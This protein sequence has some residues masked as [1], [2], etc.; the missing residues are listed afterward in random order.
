L[1]VNQQRV[2]RLIHL[3]RRRHG[4]ARIAALDRLSA[5]RAPAP[6]FVATPAPGRLSI[7]TMTPTTPPPSNAVAAAAAEV[8]ASVPHSTHMPT[9]VVAPAATPCAAAAQPASHA[10]ASATTA[11]AG[12]AHPCLP[13]SATS[14]SF[15]SCSPASAIAEPAPTGA[16]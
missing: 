6:A 14:P 12:P 4:P 15:S 11:P 13:A 1:K 10:A 9:T 5:P 3:T 16:K 7:V 2:V 8:R